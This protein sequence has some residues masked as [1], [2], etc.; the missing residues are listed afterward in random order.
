MDGVVEGRTGVG[1]T[2]WVRGSVAKEVVPASAA[3]CLLFQNVG[4]VAMYM[5]DHVTDQIADGRARMGGGVVEEP[6]D[7][8]IGLMGGL[9][10]RAASMVGSTNMA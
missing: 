4:G 3:P 8:I 9:G 6:E 2:G 10:L 1:S 5:E 7:L